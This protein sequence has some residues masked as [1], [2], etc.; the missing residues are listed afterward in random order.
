MG[1]RMTIIA[2]SLR[3]IK[4]MTVKKSLILAFLWGW[5][6]GCGAN[7]FSRIRP[8]EVVD[9]G[10]QVRRTTGAR[11]RAA[12]H[13]PR[14]SRVVEKYQGLKGQL[15]GMRSRIWSARP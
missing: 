4:A 11:S 15:G 14:R 8:G 5:I 3:P 12:R 9:T 7:D 10:G 2:D 1:T 6:V 13:T